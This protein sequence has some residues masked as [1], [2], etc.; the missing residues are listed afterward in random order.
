[1]NTTE[2]TVKALHDDI[3]RKVINEK[4]PDGTYNID[5]LSPVSFNKGYQVTFY[6]V[7]MNYTDEAYEALVSLFLEFSADG[8]TYLGFF[9]GGAEISWRIADKKTAIRL[10]KQFNQVAVWD[11]KKCDCIATDGTGRTE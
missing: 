10:A 3:I 4:F 11:W 6:T 7:G 9:D 8:I 2:K 5:T 1:M